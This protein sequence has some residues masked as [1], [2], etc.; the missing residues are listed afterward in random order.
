LLVFVVLSALDMSLL[1]RPCPTGART[2]L[3]LPG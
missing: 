3:T 2:A 1:L